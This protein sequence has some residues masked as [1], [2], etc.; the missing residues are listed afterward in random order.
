MNGFKILLNPSNLKLI[1]LF[2]DSIPTNFSSSFKMK[3]PPRILNQIS[4]ISTTKKASTLIL[5]HLYL[6]IM[7][8][9][10]FEHNRT[11]I[12]ESY[13]GDYTLGDKMYTAE[14]HTKTS[15]QSE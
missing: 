13:E 1:F 5:I 14:R 9:F 11:H 10:I 6:K 15:E 2:K 7:F 12:T 8:A 3:M 4:F